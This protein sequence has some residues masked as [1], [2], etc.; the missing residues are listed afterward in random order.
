MNGG[1][2]VIH[3]IDSKNEW[4]QVLRQN[5]GWFFVLTLEKAFS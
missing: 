1:Q 3:Q 5:S 2:L 4:L